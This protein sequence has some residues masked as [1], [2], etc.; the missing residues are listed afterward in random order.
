MP[1]TA[2][3]EDRLRQYEDWLA[4]IV[5]A[6][7]LATATGDDD[8]VE[9]ADTIGK[10]VEEAKTAGAGFDGFIRKAAASLAKDVMTRRYGELTEDLADLLA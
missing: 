10:V 4:R 3:V 7:M 6:D 9:V 2:T 5:Y 1:K 8:G